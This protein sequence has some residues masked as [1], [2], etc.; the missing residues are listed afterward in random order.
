[1]KIISPR[2]ARPPNRT[3]SPP[4]EQPLKKIWHRYFPVNFSK[5][6]RTPFLT[7]TTGGCSNYLCNYQPVKLFPAKCFGL[8]VASQVKWKT[9]FFE[10]FEEFEKKFELLTIIFTK[11]SIVDIRLCSEYVSEHTHQVWTIKVWNHYLSVYLF[12]I[13]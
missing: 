6:L 4:Y 10:I 7:D 1:M 5:S 3:S 8:T 13:E 11:N 12:T 2:R 9:F